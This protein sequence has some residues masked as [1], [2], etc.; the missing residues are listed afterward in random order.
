MAR[1]VMPCNVMQCAR[2]GAATAPGSWQRPRHSARGVA[3]GRLVGRRP[4]AGVCSG[5]SRWRCRQDQLHPGPV[6]AG[7]G[8]SEGHRAV[9]AWRAGRRW[10][11]LQQQAHHGR[12]G[13]VCCRVRGQHVPFG[14]TER[15]ATSCIDH[16]PCSLVGYTGGGGGKTSAAR[17]GT[18]PSVSGRPARRRASH[19][20]DLPLQPR[21]WLHTRATS[22]HTPCHTPWAAVLAL[23]ASHPPTH[24]PAG[25]QGSPAGRPALRGVRHAVPAASAATEPAAGSGE[26]HALAGRD[27]S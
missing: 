2:I 13:Q 25:M 23:A 5:R 26:R 19:A 4:A 27:Q 16:H 22:T 24:A 3:P 11:R 8:A 18:H 17:R 9:H 20:G 12:R 21:S 15:Q 14:P 10:G 6:S 7:S 1:N